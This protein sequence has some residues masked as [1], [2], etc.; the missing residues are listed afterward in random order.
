MCRNRELVVTYSLKPHSSFN[1][2]SGQVNGSKIICIVVKKSLPSFSSMVVSAHNK[3]HLAL[4]R[5]I[6]EVD[7]TS[8]EQQNLT[9]YTVSLFI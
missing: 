4:N 5:S 1:G 2:I 6:N 8:A 3:D 9:Y 7:P